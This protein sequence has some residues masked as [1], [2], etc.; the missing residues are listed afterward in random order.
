[1]AF[2]AGEDVS[3]HNLLRRDL[4]WQTAV[5]RAGALGGAA[6]FSRLENA[7]TARD[8]LHGVLLDQF[9]AGRRAQPDVTSNDSSSAMA[10]TNS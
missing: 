5:G 9:I 4:V 2:A 6:T 8:T 7:A 10:S 1:M 3:D